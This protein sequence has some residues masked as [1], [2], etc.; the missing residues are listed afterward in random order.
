MTLRKSRFAAKELGIS[1]H[2]LF[3]LLRYDRM[4]PPQKDTSGDYVWTDDDL[5]AARRA[6]A[7]MHGRRRS[8][9]EAV[10]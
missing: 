3:A 2:Q 6:L 9:N 5:D 1:Y 10:S 8:K 7:E 4:T